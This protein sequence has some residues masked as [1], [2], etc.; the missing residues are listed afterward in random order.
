MNIA[1]L[2]VTRVGRQNGHQLL[3]KVGIGLYLWMFLV[4]GI[5]ERES[6]YGNDLSLPS[7]TAMA[8]IPLIKKSFYQ[9]LQ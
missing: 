6:S 7:M 1:P 8:G 5:L 2:N 3:E 4:G 9:Q